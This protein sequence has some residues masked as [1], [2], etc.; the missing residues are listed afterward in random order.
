MG[1]FLSSSPPP[2]FSCLF[3]FIHCLNLPSLVCVSSVFLLLLF[4]V[5]F[6]FLLR[7]ATV[8]YMHTYTRNLPRPSKHTITRKVQFSDWYAFNSSDNTRT[9]RNRKCFCLFV[10]F[11]VYIKTHTSHILWILHLQDSSQEMRNLKKKT[12]YQLLLF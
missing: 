4:F 10:C 3:F 8:T 9:F 2:P 5:L 7:R 12:Y 11:S 1:L 6:S